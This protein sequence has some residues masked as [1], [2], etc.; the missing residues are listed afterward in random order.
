MRIRPGLAIDLG[1]VNTLVHVAGR[2]IVVDEPSAVA[3]DG[4]GRAVA[5]GAA[6]DAISGKAPEG[7]EVV[8]PLRD[9]VV[10]D[11]EAV[12]LMLNGFLRRA[13]VHRGLMRPTAVLCVPRGATS[14]ERQAVEA[15]VRALSP[16]CGLRM[17]EE[18]VAAAVGA[19]MTAPGTAGA[20]VVDI[21]GGTTE[22]AAVA[23]GG[24]VRARSLRVA[25]NSMDAAI[26]RAVRSELG[27]SLGHRSAERLKIGLGLTGGESAVE[28]AAVDAASGALRT[29]RVPGSL[30]AAAI[31]PAV[32]AIVEVVGEV[33]SDPDIAAGH[34]TGCPSTAIAPVVSSVT[35]KARPTSTTASPVPADG[36]ATMVEDDLEH[37]FANSRA[38]RGG[39][40]GPSGVSR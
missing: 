20:F 38:I 29:A 3:L 12:I 19:G 31:E 4:A 16:H 23:G 15:A 7:T 5:I 8:W 24:V 21:G 11:I 30:V 1:T 6:A 36:V 34:A 14:F 22:V 26:A 18:P 2:G 13:H 35:T 9:G 40:G 28:V 39:D 37:G 10:A 17:I 32:R 27:F 33:L 25:G